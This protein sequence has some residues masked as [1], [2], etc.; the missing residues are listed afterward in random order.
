LPWYHGPADWH[1]CDLPDSLRNF[2]TTLSG[3]LF[4]R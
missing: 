2:V 1:L 4:S 3:S